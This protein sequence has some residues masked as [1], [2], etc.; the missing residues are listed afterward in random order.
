MVCPPP[1]RAGRGEGPPP[2]LRRNHSLPGCGSVG[3]RRR[4]ARLCLP[5]AIWAAVMGSWHGAQSVSR[6]VRLS[7][8]PSARPWM[9][10]ISRLLVAPHFTQACP[11]RCRTFLRRWVGTALGA[12][13]RRLLRMLFP[14]L[15][16]CPCECLGRL[17]GLLAWLCVL[18]WFA[19]RLCG[20]CRGCLLSGAC[21]CAPGRWG[22]AWGEGGCV[23]G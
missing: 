8:P 2:P 7:S 4:A 23:A 19:M 18:W 14:P 13:G 10:L 3:S 9:W 11:S 22:G 1:S 16:R 5:R 15:C 12:L 17:A 21:G 20:C 6:F